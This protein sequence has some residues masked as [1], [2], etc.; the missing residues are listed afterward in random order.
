MSGSEHVQVA[1][2]LVANRSGSEQVY[3]VANRCRVRTGR[4]R[5]DHKPYSNTE[6]LS[7][8]NQPIM[9]KW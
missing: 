4:S 7:T 8:G 9:Q 1:N 5:I 6:F 2:A 3:Q